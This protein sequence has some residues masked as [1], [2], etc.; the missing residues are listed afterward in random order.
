MKRSAAESV[1][2]RGVRRVSIEF[3]GHLEIRAPDSA[4]LLESE[5]TEGRDRPPVSGKRRGLGNAGACPELRLQ[6]QRFAPEKE[7]GRLKA[8]LS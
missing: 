8:G 7:K 3:A 6:A 4:S 1:K 5:M 2:G